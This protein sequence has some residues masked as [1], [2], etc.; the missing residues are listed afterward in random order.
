MK[1][2]ILEKN[3]TAATSVATIAQDQAIWRSTK[4]LTLEKNNSA[5]LSV[6][7]NAQDQVI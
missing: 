5:A 6:I 3:H 4:E 2:S 7:I 1:E